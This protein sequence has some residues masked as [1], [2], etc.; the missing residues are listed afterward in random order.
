MSPAISYGLGCLTTLVVGWAAHEIGWIQVRIA[1]EAHDLN[2]SK[3]VPKIGT[4]T[5][6]EKR[7]ITS[8]TV[9]LLHIVTR[10]YNEGEL[11]AS[12]IRGE[13]KLSSINGAFNHTIPI[14][15]DHLGKSG[16]H[17]IERKNGG[18]KTWRDME[19]GK[20]LGIAVEINFRY[21]GLEEEGEHE[22]RATYRYDA[23]QRQLMRVE[24]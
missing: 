21:Q 10:L 24:S 23:A 9:W 8:H 3:A 1:A 20:D 6:V 4:T 22:Y 19:G 11:A 16:P 13:W 2:V 15:L 7:E 17:D 18:V 12:K 5:R 14:A